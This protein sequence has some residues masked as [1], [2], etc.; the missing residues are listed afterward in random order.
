VRLRSAV[1][2]FACVVVA[3]GGS[4]TL[5]GCG[6][7]AAD[8]ERELVAEVVQAYMS[9]AT[10]VPRHARPEMMG[11]LRC[12]KLAAAF[13]GIIEKHAAAPASTLNSVRELRE[14]CVRTA[15]IYGQAAGR[16]APGRGLPPEW[17]EANRLMEEFESRLR[18]LPGAED[19][20]RES[21]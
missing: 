8:P 15:K 18:A 3:A 14:L 20:L 12:E 1:V 10:S 21:E 13:E 17:H 19:A 11:K 9:Q 16:I 7:S 6:R 2:I 5:G 4:V